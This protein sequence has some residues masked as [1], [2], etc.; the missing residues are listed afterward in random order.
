MPKYRRILTIIDASDTAGHVVARAA[1]LGKLLGATIALATISDEKPHAD[2]TIQARFASI[3]AATTRAEGLAGRAG[4][5]DLEVLVSERDPHALAAVIASWS[6]D[7]LVLG[8]TAPGGLV[9]WLDI[10]RSI[11]GQGEALDVLTVEP[12]KQGLGRRFAAAL[13]GL[14]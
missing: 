11:Q 13:S 10:L 14:F 5:R 3:S 7:L 12:K 4:L 9:G 2:Q 8:P 1:L 6:P